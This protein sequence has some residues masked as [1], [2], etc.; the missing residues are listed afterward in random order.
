MA[1]YFHRV[2]LLVPAAKQATVNSWVQANLDSA[3]GPWFSAGLSPSGNAPATY[4]WCSV[5]LTGPQLVALLRKL[6][7]LASLTPP[8]DFDSYTRQ[9][10][11]AWVLSQQSTIYSAT[12]LWIDRCDNDGLDWDDPAG[13]LAVVGLQ[14]IN[15]QP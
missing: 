14:V 1:G 3:G 12:G 10:Q 11:A 6:C 4:Y 9:Q 8:A 2:I 5:G 7:Q 13:A 15:S